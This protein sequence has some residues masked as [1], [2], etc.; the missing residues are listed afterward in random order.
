MAAEEPAS[1]KAKHVASADAGGYHDLK[2]GYVHKKWVTEKAD[3]SPLANGCQSLVIDGQAVMESW[4]KPY[5]AALAEVATRK[6]GRVL[7]V[8]FGLHIS[9]D[10]VQTHKIDEH[11]IIEANA[12][13]FESCKKWASEQK[14]KVTPMHGLWQDQI[15]L[16][17]DNSLDGILYDTYP[18]NAEEQHTHQFDFLK[19]A[20]K[21]LKVGGI[22]TY[23]NLTSIGL[24]KTKH[25]DWKEM[26]EKT[27]KPH[28]LAMGCKEEDIE[29]FEIHKGLEP[30]KDC[31]YYHH[32]E[33]LCPVIIKKS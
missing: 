27:Q 17:E 19:A 33:A 22:M 6:G 20:F 16:V 31:R 1:K 30:P 13:V 29:P 7:E 10:A 21:K 32:S 15:A 2:E 25:P 11:I 28:L 5:M 23:C 8:G 26:F 3:F 4:E 12:D 18:L 24:L 9:A 14:N